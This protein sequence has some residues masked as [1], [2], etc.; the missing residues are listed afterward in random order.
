MKIDVAKIRTF[1]LRNNMYQYELAKK[2]SITESH[3]SKILRG[4]E[5]PS[6][7]LEERICGVIN[8]HISGN[9]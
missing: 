4:R 9:G 6:K 8:Q 3:L 2:L 7:G 5:K 1:L